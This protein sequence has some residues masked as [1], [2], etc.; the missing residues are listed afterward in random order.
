MLTPFLREDQLDYGWNFFNK[1]FIYFANPN[2][3]ALRHKAN[4]QE[5][6]KIK[7]H[8]YT[9]YII[10]MM[11]RRDAQFL[12]RFDRGFLERLGQV[13]AEEGLLQS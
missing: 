10:I 11:R 12:I 3:I 1:C 9:T 8:K 13:S 5:S 7:L 4:V 6:L 2:T